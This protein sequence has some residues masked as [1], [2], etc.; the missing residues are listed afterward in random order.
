[1]TNLV[2]DVRVLD[3]AVTGQEQDLGEHLGGSSII[4]GEREEKA[5]AML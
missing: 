5:S 1:M 2:E 3:F 4:V